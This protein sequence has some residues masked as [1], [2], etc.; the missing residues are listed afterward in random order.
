MALLVE[1]ARAEDI[2]Q[3]RAVLRQAEAGL[4]VATDDAVRMRE[5]ARTGSVTPKQRDDAE[6]RLTVAE[7]QRSA[8]A[9]AVRKLERLARPAEVRAA[10]AG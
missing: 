3:A 10:E 4:K 1:G 9:E 2:Q 6:A 8:A 5:L 7:T